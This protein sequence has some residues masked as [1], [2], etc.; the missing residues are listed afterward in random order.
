MDIKIELAAPRDAVFEQLM[1]YGLQQKAIEA[2]VAACRKN[3]FWQLQTPRLPQPPQ[4]AA[5]Y[6]LLQQHWRGHDPE[7]GHNWDFF[8]EIMTFAEGLFLNRD[9]EAV[10]T[11]ILLTLLYSR[12]DLF[13][14]W[15]ALLQPARP[16]RAATW[17]ERYPHAEAVS[18]FIAQVRANPAAWLSIYGPENFTAWLLL[19]L[20]PAYLKYCHQQWEL[21]RVGQLK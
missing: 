1:Q 18:V 6:H 2:A 15:F 3:D 9:N 20:L 17:A 21:D 7:S 5:V 10:A 14:C 12:A 16:A 8:G 19:E 13:L 11:D 4:P